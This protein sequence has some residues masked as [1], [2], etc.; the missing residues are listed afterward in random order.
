MP[1]L[2][3]SWDISTDGTVYTFHLRTNAKFHDGRPVVAQDVI[4]SWER[5]A[6]PAT[7]SDTVLTYLGDIVGVAEMH[8]G[9]ANSISGLKALDDH[10]LQVT[11]DAAKP[12]FLFKLT[13]PVAFVLDQKNVES[14]SEWYRTPNGTGPYKLTR[15]DSFQLMVY[16]ANQDFYLGAPSIPQIV[17][18]LYS[19][20]DIRLFESGEIDMP[21]STLPMWRASLTRLILCMPTLSQRREPVH[22]LR[23]F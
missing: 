12:Y 4:Y 20:I 13:M 23:C 9:T 6:N 14:G 5:A 22:R 3:E 17:V 21:A 11:I 15:W 7:Q 8:D 1:E 10:T 2:A 18:E 19:G 16:D